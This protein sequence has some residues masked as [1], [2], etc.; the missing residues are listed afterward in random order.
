MQVIMSGSRRISTKG[1]NRAVPRVSRPPAPEPTMPNEQTGK[2]KKHKS[3]SSTHHRDGSIRGSHRKARGSS[4]ESSSKHE[5]RQ[6]PVDTVVPNGIQL[7]AAASSRAYKEV[8]F[9]I[10]ELFS[11]RVPTVGRGK[12]FDHEK[13][14]PFVR[15]M[16]FTANRLHD[17]GK[18]KKRT[19]LIQN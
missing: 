13:S 16:L 6:T 10:N 18:S 4:R 15:E 17:D 12:T 2:N 9:K 11:N 8:L 14:E 1:K 19:T 5:P 7:T 3:S